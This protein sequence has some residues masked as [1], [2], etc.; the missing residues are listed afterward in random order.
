MNKYN[1]IDE[2][3]FLFVFFHFKNHLVHFCSY[4]LVKMLNEHKELPNI[5]IQITNHISKYKHY[6]EIMSENKK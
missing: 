5:R 3:I 2:Q 1:Q 6:K 4:L